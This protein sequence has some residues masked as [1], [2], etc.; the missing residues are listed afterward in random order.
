MGSDV[1]VICEVGRREMR[2]GLAVRRWGSGAPLV[3]L[4]GGMGSWTHWCRNI[5]ALADRFAVIAIDMPGYGDSKD[6]GP[7]SEDGYIDWVAEVFAETLADQSL[8]GIVG[9][10]FGAVIA[11][12][13]AVRRPGLVSGLSLLGPGGF[14]YRTGA[15]IALRKLPKG[16]AQSIELREAVA[17]NLGQ[18][19]LS[20]VPDAGD[21]VIDVQLRNLACSRYDNRGISARDRLVAD[22]AALTCPVQ[23]IWGGD[24]VLTYPSVQARLERCLA[25]RPDLEVKILSCGGHWVCYECAEEVNA[26]LVAFHGRGPALR[27]V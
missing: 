9:F 6:A 8:G 19:M 26:A 18:W 23:L 15:S 5:P 22:L 4:H 16:D 14:G 25:V 10:S 21:P 27:R 3:L 24:D 12:G 13:V 7:V 20:S 11:A 17:F 1:D 2:H